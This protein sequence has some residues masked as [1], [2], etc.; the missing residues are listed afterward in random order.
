M[1][2]G[3]I[4][5]AGLGD[6]RV[7]LTSEQLEELEARVE[8]GLLRECDHGW[9]D[10]LLIWNGM[11]ATTPALVLQPTSARDVAEAVSFARDRGLLLSIKGGGHSIAGTSIAEGGLTLDMSR[12]RGVAVDPEAKLVTVGP[13]CLLKDVDQATQEHG[14]ATVLG[15][16]SETGVAGL[17]LG[18]GWGYLTRRFGW[19]VDNLDEVEIVTADGKVRTAN[20]NE[21]T[22]LFWALRGGGGN[23]GVV[24]RFRFRLHEVGPII[25]GGLIIWS[26]DRVDEVLAAY[27]DVTESASREL[28]AAAIVRLAPPAPF[29]PQEWHGKPVAG[30]QVCHSG[31]DAEADLAA[32]RSVKDPIVDLVAEKPYTAQQS[33]LDAMEPKRLHRYWKTEYLP[34]LS[35]EFLNTF[36]DGALKV[37]SPMSQSVIF[38]LAGALNEREDDDGAV[39]NRDAR[40]ISGF[41]GT[42]PPGTPAEGH[43]AWVR[44]AWEAIR[45]FSTGGNYVNFQLADDDTARTADAYGRN[46]ER[47]RRVKAEYDPNNLFRV[48]RNIP[49]A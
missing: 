16:V 43:I 47:L 34:G 14:L 1:T 36:R 40:H 3:T 46:Y 17:T 4:D 13:G 37:T 23:F 18:G 10:A 32:V 12:M 8:G 19:A 21:N 15:F 41:A 44:E 33:M 45:P 9:D 2:M 22:D 35:S 29:L 7:G 42:W 27:R 5:I 49:P 48:N 11:V 24:T 38:H 28:T 39:G 20:R 30:I 6:E 25:T 31:A 26:A